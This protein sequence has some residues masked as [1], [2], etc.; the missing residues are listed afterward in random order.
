MEK[1]NVLKTDGVVR[2]IGIQDKPSR[3]PDN[4]IHWIH[5][6]IEEPSSVEN[7]KE[8]PKKQNNFTSCVLCI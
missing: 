6:M 4:E 3:I 1:L 8:I 5:R 2:F 7:E